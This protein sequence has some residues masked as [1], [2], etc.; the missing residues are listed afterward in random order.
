VA[1]LIAA[2]GWCA[3]S[4]TLYDPYAYRV[5]LKKLHWCVVCDE[6]PVTSRGLTCTSCWHRAEVEKAIRAVTHPDGSEVVD[7]DIA[8]R[9]LIEIERLRE[10]NRYLEEYE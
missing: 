6:N 8:V 1:E 5:D 3:P 10:R 9:L 2:G 7:R 4:E